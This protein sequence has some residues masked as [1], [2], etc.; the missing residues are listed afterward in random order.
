MNFNN[1]IM[2]HADLE[3]FTAIT[4]RIQELEHSNYTW[5]ELATQLA[6][7]EINTCTDQAQRRTYTAQEILALIDSTL[8]QTPVVPEAPDIS[9]SAAD[10]MARLSMKTREQRY[11]TMLKYMRENPVC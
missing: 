7:L 10:I 11:Y 6:W 2:T 5:T 4:L 1:L 8:D 3:K 9:E